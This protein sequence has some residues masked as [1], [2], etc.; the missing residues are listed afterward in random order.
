MVKNQSGSSR[1]GRLVRKSAADIL[2]RAKKPATQKERLTVR[3]DKDVVAWLRSKGEGYQTRLNTILR[4]AMA[5]D[6]K[7][8]S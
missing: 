1:Q 7:R 8:A 6:L 4:E 5:K 2:E 3:I